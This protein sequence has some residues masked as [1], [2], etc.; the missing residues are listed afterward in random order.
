MALAK[1]EQW[2]KIRSI[3]TPTFTSNKMKKMFPIVKVSTKVL[4]DV[5]DKKSNDGEIDVKQIF[6]GFSMEVISSCIFA[7]NTNSLENPNHPF[8]INGKKFFSVKTLK[9]LA[10]YVLPTSINTMLGIATIFDHDALEFFL[11][12]GQNVI[13]KRQNSKV[14][15]KFNDFLQL[16]INAENTGNISQIKDDKLDA[17]HDNEGIFIMRFI[18]LCDNYSKNM[19]VIILII[20]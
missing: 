14:D 2:K 16:L 3:V 8:L 4:L 12:L 13:R 18:R 19:N 20:C 5:L 17:Q 7:T 10:A 15:K 9:A 11:K 1:G 6:G